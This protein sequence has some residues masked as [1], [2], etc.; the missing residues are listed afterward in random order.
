MALSN[1][2]R[3]RL[4]RLR[5][6]ADPQKREAYLHKEHER[7]LKNVGKGKRKRVANMTERELRTKR[8]E[9]RKSQKES[10][11]KQKAQ[12]QFTPPSTPINEAQ[13]RG[14]RRVS[15]RRSKCYKDLQKAREL[16]KSKERAVE[17]YR[18]KLH[19]LQKTG[20]NTPRS[21]TKNLL[22]NMNPTRDVVKT[23]NF[24]YTLVDTLRSKYKKSKATR[25][26]Q[27]IA[28]ILTSKILSKY[29]MRKMMQTAV[30]VSRQLGEHSKSAKRSKQR[31][32]YTK[33]GK[34]VSDFFQRDDNSRMTSGKKQTI[35]RKKEKKQK[36]LLLDTIKNIFSKFQAEFPML[37]ISYSLFCFLRPFWVVQPSPGDR[38][39]CL[40]KVHENVTLISGKLYELKVLPTKD[41]EEMARVCA[42]NPENKNC[43]YGDCNTCKEKT[44]PVENL[45]E[46]KKLTEYQQW[47]SCQDENGY[48]II[49]KVTLTCSIKD[50]V[51]IFQTQLQNF[52]KHVFNIKN[53]YKVYKEMR[54]NL[55]PTECI[56]HIDFAENY[57]CKY[58]SEIQ[59]MHFGGS[60]RQVTMHTGVLYVGQNDVKPF[61]TLSDSTIHDPAGIWTYLDPVLDWVHKDY[62][63]INSFHF[64]SDG[65]S[66]QYRQKKNLFMF[67]S[68]M[69]TSSVATWNFFEASHGKGS[70]DGVGGAL[71]RKADSLV[72]QGVDLPDP[73]S[74]YEKLMQESS[75]KL[76]YCDHKDVEKM[77]TELSTLNIPVVPGT[78]SLHQ[79]ILVGK[80]QFIYKDVS[81]SCSLHEQKDCQCFQ[82]KFFKFPQNASKE[83]DSLIVEN[84]NKELT[85][86]QVSS[87]DINLIGKYC[88]IRYEGHIFPGKILD[89]SETG[90]EVLCMHKAG[91]NRY[92]WCS[93]IVDRMWYPFND[94]LSLISEPAPVTSSARHVQIEPAVYARILKSL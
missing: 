8:K 18:K 56:I 87:A 31:S 15:L 41:P 44:F 6:N 91:N 48:N 20:K 75:V 39:T 42:C 13:P 60:H 46:P 29:R 77:K 54:E 66:S 70:P 81:C 22:R 47:A 1:K 79:V 80:G 49:K 78:M 4:F 52:K 85:L 43:M 65:P 17:R 28:N 21:K 38:E 7:Y 53:Q 45:S 83:K 82:T 27:H 19:R 9:W 14:R 33:V 55:R 88:A 26:K 50:L 74:V 68:K 16:L 12:Q 94:I 24:H 93:T 10:R 36:R 59:A 3:Q 11:Q 32:Y 76:F 57:T 73:K 51:D 25:Q 86:E 90:L 92:Y 69:G 84:Q 61:C 2:E 72:R 34:T 40:C 89:V 30:G 37:K 63:D 64:F 58:S 5:R 35:T 62:P 71:K 23:L 67:S